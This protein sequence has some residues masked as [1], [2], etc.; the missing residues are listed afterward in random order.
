[1]QTTIQQSQKERQ[2]KRKYDLSLHTRMERR[3]ARCTCAHIPA[4]TFSHFVWS[5]LFNIAS[6]QME[7]NL[8]LDQ[9]HYYFS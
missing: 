5:A 8:F 1:M 7:G 4:Y 6:F 9:I 3:F 2:Q